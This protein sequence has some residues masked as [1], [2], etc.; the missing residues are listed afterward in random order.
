MRC[1]ACPHENRETAKFCAGCGH[2]FAE[3]CGACGAELEAGSRFC[4]QCGA[5]RDAGAAPVSRKGSAPPAEPPRPASTARLNNAPVV[6]YTPR[7]LAEKILTSRAVLEGERKLVTVLFADCAGFTKLSTGLDPEE[8]HGV[9]DGL[10]AHVLEAVHGY[11]GTV[12]QFTGDGVMALFGAPIA[13]EDHAVRGVAA[14]LAMQKAIDAYAAGLRAERGIELAL[15]IG[16]NTGQVVVGKIGDD[17]RMDYTAQGETVNLAA[18]LQAQADPGGVLVSEATHRHVAAYFVTE[19]SGPFTLKGIEGPVGAFNVLRQHSRRARFDVAVERGLTP[20]VGRGTE[21]SF[22]RDCFARVREGRGQAVSIVGDAGVGKSRLVYEL[23]RELRAAELIEIEGRCLPHGER[24]P[25]HLAIQL[26]EGGFAL[27][28]T[29]EPSARA[30]KIERDVERLDPSLTWTVPLV[31]HL[32]SLGDADLTASGLDEAQRKRRLIDAVK[33]LLLRQARETPVLVVVED[34][35]WT[36]PSSEEFLASL[37]DGL[38][39]VPL[40][41]L[42]THRP[43]YVPPWLDR[44]VHH[45]LSLGP[46]SGQE[47]EAM[48]RALLGPDVTAPI[49]QRAEGN[50]FFVEE[51]AAF[52]RERDLS[53]PPVSRAGGKRP[54]EIALPNTVNDLLTARIDRLPERLKLTVQLASVLGREFSRS[55]LDA[56]AKDGQDVAADLRELVRT[57]ILREIPAPDPRYRFSAALL[58]EVAY[59]SL[60]LKSRAE[61]HERAAEALV[62][63]SGDKPEAAAEIAAHYERTSNGEKA[64]HYF[65]RAGDRAAALFAHDEARAF[66]R[67]AL[68]LLPAGAGALREVLLERLGDE[69]Y[70][71]GQIHDALAEWSAALAAVE[72]SNGSHRCTTALHRKMAVGSF[73]SGDSK[74]AMAHLQAGVES[75]PA[76]AEDLEAARLDQELGRIYFRLGDHAKATEWA[77][78]ALALGNRLGACDVV[79]EASN[80]LGVARARAGQVDLGIAAIER[81]LATALAAGLG[82]VACRAYTNLAVMLAPVDHRRSAEYCRAGLALAEKIGDQ[83]QQSWLY[84]ALAGGHCTV[85]GEYDEGVRA[86]EAAAELDERLGQ[87]SHLPI[88]LILVAQIYQCRGETRESGERYRRALAVA[89]PI[90]DPQL[91]VPCYEGLAV[92]AIEDGDEAAA[93]EWLGRSRAMQE[94]T[95]WGEDSFLV[96][97]FLC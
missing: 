49:A 81:S 96:L 54:A 93:E 18:R 78:K 71:E 53:S 65:Q 57:E 44:S 10:F 6:S 25:F 63:T 38:E 31:K 76:G 14:A 46:L 77:E 17:L 16:M 69:S 70:A 56:L 7:H 92:V 37:V 94:K 87:R 20:L 62:R 34:L 74:A 21:L 58:P 36:D 97:P 8:L 83:L 35:Q 39:S 12:N 73:A 4:D 89:E 9:M 95:G 33:A 75:L 5:A 51:L 90:G 26:L 61:L 42:C 59:Q 48:A 24:L 55:L 40:L 91:L 43:S 80:T 79:A 45:R 67:R 84:C 47:T 19:S 1:P 11:E 86:A 29:E 60:L 27:D 66:Y 22:L 64:A 15:R 41:L 32:L 23:R 52:V 13:H 3:R 50:P 82:S 72:A 68:E 88:P 85:A 30:A 2:R 28:A